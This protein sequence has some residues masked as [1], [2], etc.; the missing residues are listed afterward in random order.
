MRQHQI[1]YY[2]DGSAHYVEVR[3]CKICGKEELELI[4]EQCVDPDEKQVDKVEKKD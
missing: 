2:S 4:N 1:A 3:Y